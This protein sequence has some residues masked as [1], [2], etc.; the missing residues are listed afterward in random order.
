MV[1]QDMIDA[2]PDLNFIFRQITV[3]F[4]FK[5]DIFKIYVLDPADNRKFRANCLYFL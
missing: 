2:I 4:Q 3:F 1:V 5:E